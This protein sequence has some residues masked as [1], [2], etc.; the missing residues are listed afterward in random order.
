MLVSTFRSKIML[1]APVEAFLVLHL[2]PPT[3][4]IRPFWAAPARLSSCSAPLPITETGSLGLRTSLVVLNFKALPFRGDFDKFRDA[5]ESLGLASTGLK[6]F[7][8]Q[9]KKLAETN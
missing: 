3:G 9:R 6:A 1:E 2:I 5:S 7:F 4:E 8:R